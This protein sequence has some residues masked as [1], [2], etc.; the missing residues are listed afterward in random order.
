MT[1]K[2]YGVFAISGTDASGVFI[3]GET[4]LDVCQFCVE[5]LNYKNFS[6]LPR[7]PSR[8]QFVATF[9]LAEFFDTYSSFFKYM[10]TGVG[11]NSTEGYTADWSTIS[12]KVRER[13]KYQCQQCSLDLNSYKQLLH[14]HHINGVKADNSESNLTPVCADCHRKQPYHQHMFIKHE[15][16][17]LI[18]H[19]RREQGL[20]SKEKWQ[21]VYDLA[22]PGMHGLINLLEQY[23]VSIPEVG[24]EIVNNKQEVI[25]E[26]E[27]AWPLK[28]VG[29]AVDK[30]AAI[31]ATK[32]GWKVYSMRHALAQIEN[33]ASSLR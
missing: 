15:E 12:K 20:N 27:L 21:D 10:P 32:Q 29:V 22:D 18:T 1:N 3:E 25:T 5:S 8:K 13:F 24:E 31:D 14:V 7:G 23:H 11:S 26:L 2:L 16:T 33:L 19:L 30:G 17:K 6:A 4:N 28:K 9:E